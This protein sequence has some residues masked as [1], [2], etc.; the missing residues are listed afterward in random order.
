MLWNKYWVNTLS[1]SPLISVRYKSSTAKVSAE[2]DS[3]IEHMLCHS[4]MIFNKNS[5]R[6]KVLSP[7]LEP[8]PLQQRIKKAKTKKK[9]RKK[10]INWQRALKIGTWCT[11]RHDPI[12]K[13]FDLRTLPQHKDCSRSATRAHS[14]GFERCDL[15]DTSEFSVDVEDGRTFTSGWYGDWLKLWMHHHVFVCLTFPCIH[16]TIII[17]GCRWASRTFHRIA[18]SNLVLERT[19]G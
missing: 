1:Q 13:V 19:A 15:F 16:C 14:T 12:L 17:C 2:I 10:T 18:S 4:S 11:T 7:P 8:H 9:G 6:H 3:R 5:P